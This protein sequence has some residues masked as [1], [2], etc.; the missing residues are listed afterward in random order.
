MGGD[1]LRVAV[2]GAGIGGLAAAN[3]LVRRGIGVSVYEQAAALTEVGAGI[4]LQPNGIRMLRR[5]GF[6]DELAQLGSR[7]LDSQFLRANGSYAAS[8]WPAELASQIEFYGIHRADMLAM[9]AAR[10]PAHAVKAGFKCIGFE[11]NDRRAVVRFDNG[12]CIQ[13]DAVVAADGIHSRLQQHV[14]MPLAPV[15]SDT[16]AYRGIV[17]ARNTEWPAG[18]MRIWLGAGKHFL[19]YPLRAGTLLNCAGYVPSDAEM[20][21]SWSAPGDP[22]ALAREFADFDPKVGSIIAQ[23]TETFRWGLY[24]REP[25]QK[26]AHGRLALLGDAAHPMLPHS[27]QGANQA[28]EDAVTL[29]EVLCGSDRSSVPRSLQ[30]YETLRRERCTRVQR[31]SRVNGE[32]YDATGH[33]ADRDRMLG[34]QVQE[35]AWVWDYDAEFE[36][37]RALS[38]L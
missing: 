18:A 38:I 23:M 3:A 7:W 22:R 28:V 4:V 25:L 14:V 32:R 5:L 29:A 10:L 27:G 20:K 1:E 6:A 13:A 15:R 36:A 9:L 26:F 24:D 19:V 12:K 21:E 16:I 35:R 33:L 37:S 34:A 30:V 31:S 8:M 2:I 17:P 11:Q